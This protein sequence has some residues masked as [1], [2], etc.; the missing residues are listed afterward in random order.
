MLAGVAL[1][2]V[3]VV[4]LYL[5]D[6]VARTGSWWQSTL[7][8][9]GVGFVVGGIVDVTSISLLN[10]VLSGTGQFRRLNREAQRILDE[11]ANPSALDLDRAGQ[12]SAVVQATVQRDG[13]AIDP[14]L[15]KRLIDLQQRLDERSD[16]LRRSR[17]TEAA[18]TGGWLA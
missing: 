11:F 5:S 12:A 4:C 13:D 1:V 6:A 18:K 9:F 8:A 10:Q 15:R 3:G 7:D 16:E 17:A 2:L 14:V